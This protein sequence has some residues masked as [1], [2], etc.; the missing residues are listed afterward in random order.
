MQQSSQDI[1]TNER[2]YMQLA[3]TSGYYPWARYL[4]PLPPM[5]GR[6]HYPRGWSG[7]KDPEL[8]PVRPKV[9]GTRDKGLKA[10]KFR[11]LLW[12]LRV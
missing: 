3:Q 4:P 8:Y 11:Q 12:W 1:D 5:P 6:A 9:P 10:E 7:Y 2:A